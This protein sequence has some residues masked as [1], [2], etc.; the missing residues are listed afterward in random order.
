MVNQNE[1]FRKHAL[2]SFRELLTAVT[3]DP[4]MLVW[5]NGNQNVRQ[6]P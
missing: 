6:R 1:L 5:L 2:G 4:A 3:T